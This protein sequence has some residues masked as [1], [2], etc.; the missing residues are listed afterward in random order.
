[1]VQ[2]PDGL[3]QMVSSYRRK[4]IMHIQLPAEWITQGAQ[5]DLA[6]DITEDA[7]RPDRPTRPPPSSREEQQPAS[8]R[9]LELVPSVGA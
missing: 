1:M 8:G 7:T 9:W 6:L 4:T 3:L 5:A 2:T